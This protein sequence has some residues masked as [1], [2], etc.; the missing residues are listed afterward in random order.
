MEKQEG[1]A[2]PVVPLFPGYKV[3][4]KRVYTERDSLNHKKL[5][6]Y[7]ELIREA[8]CLWKLFHLLIVHER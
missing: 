8:K 2:T 5:S 6:L 4:G 1:V 7:T 3:V